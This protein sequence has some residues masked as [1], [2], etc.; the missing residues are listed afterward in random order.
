MTE[1]GL[2]SRQT[3]QTGA[4][5][6]SVRELAGKIFET[7]PTLGRMMRRERLD[8]SGDFQRIHM[9]KHLMGGPLA[10]AKLAEH[11][12][13]NP[14]ALSKL[15]DNLEQKGYVTRMVDPEDRRRMVIGL[16]EEGRTIQHKMRIQAMEQVNRSLKTLTPEERA[17]LSEALN[18]VTKMIKSNQK[19]GR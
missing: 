18:I 1:T 2:Q 7:L 14:S 4:A 3:N 15:I 17:T 13:M 11:L 10:Q 12:Q 9:L 5:D 19:E 16:T 6:V 8:G